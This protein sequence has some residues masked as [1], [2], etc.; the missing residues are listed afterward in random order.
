M[1]NIRKIVADTPGHKG[2]TYCVGN[3]QLR[4]AKYATGENG[5][6][7]HVVSVMKKRSGEF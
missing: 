2:V 4:I 5:Q 7:C 6:F 1:F 3:W